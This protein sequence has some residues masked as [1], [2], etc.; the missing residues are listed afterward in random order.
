LIRLIILFFLPP[1]L[2]PKCFLCP[3]G[4]REIL[5]SPR[6]PPRQR[7]QFPMS[8]APPLARPTPPALTLLLHYTQYRFELIGLMRRPPQPF[9]DLI[10]GWSRC[11][12]SPFRGSG[13]VWLGFFSRCAGHGAAPL[14]VCDF[15]FFLF[16]P[17]L[18]LTLLAFFTTTKSVVHRERGLPP[19]WTHHPTHGLERERDTLNLRP[20]SACTCC[21][22]IW[23]SP[24]PPR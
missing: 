11:S 1:Y 6:P 10:A 19:G 4:T 2:I 9:G 17:P 14:T 5:L 21:F 23:I 18:P 24:L 7:R 16:F 8:S 20:P 22:S 15:L 12:R 13:R 3:G